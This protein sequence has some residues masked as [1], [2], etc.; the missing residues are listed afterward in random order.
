MAENPPEPA[1]EGDDVKPDFGQSDNVDVDPTQGAINMGFDDN[2]EPPAE[3][4]GKEDE[5]VS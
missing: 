3:E 5:E 2:D 4:T 1:K